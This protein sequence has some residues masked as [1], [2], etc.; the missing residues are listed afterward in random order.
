M[1]TAS[2]FAFG[3]L[4]V[5]TMIVAD[6]SRS[7]AVAPASGPSCRSPSRTMTRLEL[8]FGSSRQSR[9]TI[10]DD[11]WASFVDSEVTPRFPAGL[12]VLRGPGQWRGQDGILAKEESRILVVWHEPSRQSEIDIEAIRT[13]YK[14]RF[15]QESVIRVEGVSCVSF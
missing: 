9:P 6:Y 2:L 5:G 10:S 7:A 14:T 12:T 3:I 13:A 8:L 1:N 4:V 11:E 15:E